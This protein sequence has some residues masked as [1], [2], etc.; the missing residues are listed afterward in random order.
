MAFG[1]LGGAGLA[2]TILALSA[3]LDFM[4][5]SDRIA[6]TWGRPASVGV[7]RASDPQASGT[8]LD[9]PANRGFHSALPV[10]SNAPGEVPAATLKSTHR[11]S[12]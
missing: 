8:N 10:A 7:A 1:A 6:A 5:G 2:M 4:T 12:G 11:A 9:R 3:A